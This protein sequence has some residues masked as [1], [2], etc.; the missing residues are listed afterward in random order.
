MI[1]VLN[2]ETCISC[3]ICVSVC[4]TNVF[5]RKT[6]GVPAIARVDD[7]QTCFMCE[8]YCPVDALYVAPDAE[9]LTGIRVTDLPEDI[10]GEYRKQVFKHDKIHASK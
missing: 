5:D 1:E 3:N 9:Q 10:I 2:E 7:C 8:A 4:P 6:D